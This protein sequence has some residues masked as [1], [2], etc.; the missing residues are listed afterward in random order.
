MSESTNQLYWFSGTFKR[1]SQCAHAV[2]GSLPAFCLIKC[3]FRFNSEQNTRYK[4]D[5]FESAVR[6]H[7]SA[8]ERE[9]FAGGTFCLQSASLTTLSVTHRGFSWGRKICRKR[10]CKHRWH[11]LFDNTSYL[12]TYFLCGAPLLSS[13]QIL[14]LAS[15]PPPQ[16]V[17]TTSIWFSD[18]L[19][20]CFRS[21]HLLWIT[22]VCCKEEITMRFTAFGLGCSSL[23]SL[24]SRCLFVPLMPALKKHEGI[25]LFCFCA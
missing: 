7:T 19:F 8:P 24:G 15:P 22:H 12:V 25:N 2:G 9:L 5:A 13:P 14:P 10:M 16:P 21:S 1:E 3:T 18:N 17:L 20:Y 23:V 11:A 4:S 6:S